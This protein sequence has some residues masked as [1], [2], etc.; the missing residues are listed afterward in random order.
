MFSTALQLFSKMYKEFRLVDD[1][2]MVTVLSACAQS[3]VIR[4]GELFMPVCCEAWL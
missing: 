3:R 4:Q 2:L 1:M